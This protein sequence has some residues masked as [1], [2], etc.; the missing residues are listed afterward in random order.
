MIEENDTADT[1]TIRALKETIRTLTQALQQEKVRILHSKDPKLSETYNTTNNALRAAEKRYEE[2][3][4]TSYEQ[5]PQVNR[6]RNRTFSGEQVTTHK[7]GDEKSSEHS[8]SP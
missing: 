5:S 3:T 7:S 4:G 6:Y 8:H 1:E 2:L